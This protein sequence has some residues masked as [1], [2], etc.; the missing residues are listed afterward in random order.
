MIVHQ[1]TIAVNPHIYA[2]LPY[3]PLADFAPITRLG[4]GPLVLAVNASLPVKTVKDLVA[5]GKERKAPLAFG[6]PGIGTPPHLAGELFKIDAGIPAL[7]VPYRGGGAAA[8]D[9]I[10]GHVDFSIE[11]MN[12]LLPHIQ[13]GRLRA[14]A[15]T[16][17]QRV[18]ALPDIPTVQEAGVPGYIFRGWVGISAPV[19][20]P[21]AVVVKAYEAIAQVLGTQEA[22]DWFGSVGADPGAQTPEAFS[23]FIREE[24]EKWGR[25]IQ[26]AGIRAE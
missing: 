23:A 7:H 15:T 18:A 6:S 21:R 26:A 10:A 1:G 9:L 4:F 5:L 14:L 13:A 3:D 22:R 11:G 8:S 24:Y 19:A 20:T 25:V 2:R 17:H 16:G 12:V